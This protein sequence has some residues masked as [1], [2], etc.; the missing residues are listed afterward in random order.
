MELSFIRRSCPINDAIS[1]TCHTCVRHLNIQ[2]ITT[3]YFLCLSD[4]DFA[5]DVAYIEECNITL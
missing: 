5:V 3:N 4:G 2:I 1:Q